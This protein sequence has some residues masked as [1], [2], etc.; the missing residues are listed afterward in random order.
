[1]TIGTADA[2]VAS[3][4][5]FTR[6]YTRRLG[7][8][9]EALLGS[10]FNLAEAR[11]VYEVAL[12]QRVTASDLSGAL[13]LDAGYLSRLLKG[14]ERRGF[15]TRKVAEGD[16]RQSLLKLTGKGRREFEKLN[17]RSDLE[18]GKLLA[19]LGAS[20]RTALRTALATAKALLGAHNGHCQCIFRD[21]RPGDM[22][23]IVHRQA[24][25]YALEYGWDTTFEAL[26]AKVGGEFI[27]NFDAKYERAWVAEIDERIVGSVFVVKKSKTVAKLRLLYVEPDL[28]GQGI[29]QRLVEACIAHARKLGYKRMTL[30]TNDVLTAARRIYE[31]TGFELIHSEPHRSFGKDLVG[32]TWERDL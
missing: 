18:V 14:L 29:G 28:R 1:M 2:T 11:I 16:A 24:L 22:G 9:Q 6:F 19:P 5:G 4:R 23:W 10:E 3:V 21:L 7:V 15:L 25:L 26:V 20:G 13:D 12:G 8:L 32:E 27:E 17:A 31:T 30:W